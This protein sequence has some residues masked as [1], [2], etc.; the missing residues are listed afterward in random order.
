M[1]LTQ[2]TVLRIVFL[3]V[4]FALFLIIIFP[5]FRQEM[6]FGVQTI[7]KKG[8]ALMLDIQTREYNTLE[9]D[10]FTIR[11]L[12]SDQEIAPYILDMAEDYY[13]T[14][15]DLLGCPETFRGRIPLVLYPD[16][17]SLARSFGQKGD[18]RAVGVYWAG[19]IRLLS[20]EVWTDAG[21]NG[22]LV[23]ARFREEG[24]LAHEITH[25]IIDFRTRGNYSRWFTE[26]MAQFV[27]RE[28][29]GFTLDEPSPSQKALRLSPRLVEA[30]FDSA[31]HQ[32][33]A[34][35]RSL[36]AVDFLMDNYGLDTMKSLLKELAKGE[37]FDKTF[38]KVYDFTPETLFDAI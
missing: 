24:P 29:T 22:D 19:S 33:Y 27:E 1:M 26:G 34:Y 32:L 8:I 23:R 28:I 20:P 7:F 4:I 2:N 12:D 17:D 9:G 18:K 14:V 38:L 11:F 5:G 30:A 36:G 35:W 3:I 16:A 6:R 21:S 10:Q 25:L 13:R 37:P 15:A 31:K